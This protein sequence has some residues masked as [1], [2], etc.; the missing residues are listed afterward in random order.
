MKA[1]L[2]GTGA[3][4][5]KAVLTAIDKG[6][7]PEDQVIFINSTSKDFPAGAKAENCIVLSPQDN[8]CGKERSTAKEYTLQA[9]K[10][11]KLNLAEK[12]ED[13]DIVVVVT[14]L[15][16]GTGSG[17]APIIA[18]YTD[19]MLGK[20][21][22][23][24]GFTGFEEDVRGLQNTIEFFKEL[25]DEFT[26]QTIRNSEFLRE[27][28]GNK[29]R[30]EELANIEL[31]RRIDILLGNGLINSSQNIDSTDIYKVVNTTGYMTVEKAVINGE[32]LSVE[33]F[34][35]ICKNMV[36]KSK[37][38][39]SED[40]ALSRLGVIINV[41]EEHEDAID[42]T[43]RVFKEAYGI[44]YECFTQK[45]Y[46]GSDEYI[47]FIASGMKMPLDEV[48]A[49]HQRYV[50][51]T[52]KVDKKEDTFFSEVGGLKGEAIDSR[53]N[54]GTPSNNKKDTI[55]QDDFFKQF[56]SGKKGKE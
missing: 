51:E 3:A 26:V 53:F 54:M 46:D 10:S 29:Y 33:D 41:A 28:R 32:L 27:A 45:Q 43:Y 22:H 7:I 24:V 4:G 13:V 6:V 2:I 37:S 31:A 49:I 35:K 21:T 23:I 19:Q 15:E 47:S 14:S 1:L 52:Q 25:D 44:P 18:K 17:S 9:I 50:E 11:Q 5:N 34:D 8:G 30:A 56:Q 38:I 16:G 12:A 40:K 42:T 36:L 20:N 39:K 48:K 55:S